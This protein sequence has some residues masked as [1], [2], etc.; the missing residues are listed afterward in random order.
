MSATE[1]TSQPDPV[2]SEKA[3]RQS[4]SVE[5]WMRPAT[6]S[7]SARDPE[8]MESVTDPT[9]FLSMPP[10]QKETVSGTSPDSLR[11]PLISAESPPSERMSQ[12]PPRA[13]V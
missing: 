9:P 10:S 13:M 5:G 2:L 3:A 8:R 4:S 11:M 7:A 12:S 1:E 6:L